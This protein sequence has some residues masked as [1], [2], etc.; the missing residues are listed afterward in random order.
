MSRPDDRVKD[1]RV[2][3][4][5]EKSKGGATLPAPE[6]SKQKT[7]YPLLGQSRSQYLRT[8]SEVLEH[9]ERVTGHGEWSP[10]PLA[11]ETR[12]AYREAAGRCARHGAIPEADIGGFMSPDAL[13]W[14]RADKLIGKSSAGW[15]LTKVEKPPENKYPARPGDPTGIPHASRLVQR[16][17][18]LIVHADVTA[19]GPPPGLFPSYVYDDFNARRKHGVSLPAWVWAAMVNMHPAMKNWHPI[20]RKTASRRLAEL[21][22]L[23][24]LVQTKATTTLYDPVS[25]DFKVLPAAWDTPRPGIVAVIREPRARKPKITDDA[26]GASPPAPAEWRLQRLRW[27]YRA[28]DAGFG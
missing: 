15:M 9:A 3:M 14:L 7:I 17:L 23:G 2:T 27:A 1:G 21:G 6:K 22:A 8:P 16:E 13:R 26:E 28:R 19:N 18:F 11:R 25:N 10:F 12:A 24:L 4:I 20:S 5:M